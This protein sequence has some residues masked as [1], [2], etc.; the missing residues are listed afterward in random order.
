MILSRIGIKSIINRGKVMV[1]EESFRLNIK[2]SKRI[3]IIVNRCILMVRIYKV[4]GRIVY[5]IY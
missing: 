5:K 1:V 4:N 2:V 3:C